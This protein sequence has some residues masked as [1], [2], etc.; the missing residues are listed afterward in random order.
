M[1]LIDADSLFKKLFI[2]KGKELPDNGY[3]NAPF[4]LDI[5]YLKEVIRNAPTAY[6]VDKVVER[7]EECK[8]IMESPVQQDCFGEECNAGDC[9][10]CAFEKAIEIV[11]TSGV[12]E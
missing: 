5:K 11:K 3:R 9:I 12:N 6:D 4:T 10:V 8:E 7:L 1:R 2:R